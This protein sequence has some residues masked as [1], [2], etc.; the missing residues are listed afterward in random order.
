M[1]TVG[2][3]V[4]LDHISSVCRAL[5]GPQ[6]QLKQVFWCFVKQPFNPV[7]THG[8]GAGHSP[9]HFRR[10]GG[11]KVAAR[12]GVPRGVDFAPEIWSIRSHESA[13]WRW[14]CALRDGSRWIV[15]TLYQRAAAFFLSAASIFVHWQPCLCCPC[16]ADP[17]CEAVSYCS[18]HLFDFVTWQWSDRCGTPKRSENWCQLTILT[19]V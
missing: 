4:S 9:A 19:R 17:L 6:I 12:G 13:E 1:T 18:C 10:S 14:T 7:F 3:G 15:L 11:I 5:K 8:G 2:T 16:E